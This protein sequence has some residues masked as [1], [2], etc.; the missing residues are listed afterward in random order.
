MQNNLSDTLICQIGMLEQGDV[1]KYRKYGKEMQA[2]FTGARKDSNQ[3]VIRKTANTHDTIGVEQLI[4]KVEDPD[5]REG[6]HA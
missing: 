3:I 2:F 1:V 4:E 6:V 5:I